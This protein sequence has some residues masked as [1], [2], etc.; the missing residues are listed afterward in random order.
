[1]KMIYHVRW[2]DYGIAGRKMDGVEAG[3]MSASERLTSFVALRLP[4][5]G[6]TPCPPR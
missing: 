1:M 3:R 6:G 2:D 5:S 4:P